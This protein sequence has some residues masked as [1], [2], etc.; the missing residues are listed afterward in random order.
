[1]TNFWLVVRLSKDENNEPN[2]TL[3]FSKVWLQELRLVSDSCMNWLP[4]IKELN[5]TK[6]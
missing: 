2:Y 4:K 5:I 1:M 6:N 3:K